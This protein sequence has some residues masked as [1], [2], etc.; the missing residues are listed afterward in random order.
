[1]ATVHFWPPAVGDRKALRA[2]LRLPAVGH[3]PHPQEA[4]CPRPG[5]L[6]HS[7]PCQLPPLARPIAPR[8]QAPGTLG[9]KE[10]DEDGDGG[11]EHTGRDDVDD[12]EEGLA[13]DEQVE[14]HLLV[15]R[16]LCR[17]RS[18]Q[19]HLGGPVPDGPLSILCERQARR[20][21][22]WAGQAPAARLCP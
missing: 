22:Q 8:P 3:S 7:L 15:A 5:S 2:G 19:E 17:G 14:D 11:D 4:H 16:L 13:L 12:V 1:M 9:R 18:V 10:V 21:R 6:C 20:A